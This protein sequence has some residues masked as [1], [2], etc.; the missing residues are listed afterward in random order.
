MLSGLS[1]LPARIDNA[2][3]VD[4]SEEVARAN[5]VASNG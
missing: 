5:T 1:L 4:V 3:V 2:M